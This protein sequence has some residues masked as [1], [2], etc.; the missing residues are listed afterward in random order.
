MRKE[1]AYTRA[2][3]KPELSAR[4]LRMA[5]LYDS[6]CGFFRYHTVTDYTEKS[7]LGSK[8]KYGAVMIEVDGRPY[9]AA[10]LA[11]LYTKGFWPKGSIG[12]KDG[13]LANFYL[14]NLKV[15]KQ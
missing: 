10:H 1:I 5:M 12:H 13:N 2:Y 8:N 14:R 4:T 6:A 7:H 9:P 11:I 3:A 15:E